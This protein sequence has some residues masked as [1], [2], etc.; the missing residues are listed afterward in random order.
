MPFLL[1]IKKNVIKPDSGKGINVINVIKKP[2][3]QGE[4]LSSFQTLSTEM[5]TRGT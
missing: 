1:K 4:L 3:I 5:W 2:P